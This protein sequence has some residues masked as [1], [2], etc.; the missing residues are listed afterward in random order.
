MGN[1]IPPELAAKYQELDNVI[2]DIAKLEGIPDDAI[3]S[4]WV[5]ST[6]VVAF[7][8]EDGYMHND[9]Q[10]LT[11]NAGATQTAWQTIGI[12]ETALNKVKALET[13]RFISCDHD[14]EDGDH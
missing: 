11:P 13:H 1:N 10:V 6:G 7:D 3:V 5:L 9:V 14:E 4:S 12:M 8:P 2:Q